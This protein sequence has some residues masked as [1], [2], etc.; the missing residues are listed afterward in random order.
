MNRL[1]ALI[2]VA[3]LLFPSVTFDGLTEAWVARYAG[4][5][6]GRAMT[7]DASDNVYVTGYSC[8]AIDP[9]TGDCSG[10]YLTTLKYG[11]SGVTLWTAHYYPGES[12][13]FF[14]THIATLAL[15]PAGNVYVTGMSA[16]SNDNFNDYVT[17]KYNTADGSQAWAARYGSPRYTNSEPAAIGLDSAGNVYVTGLS[18]DSVS[19]YDFATIKYDPLGTQLWVARFNGPSVDSTDAANALAVDA[20]GNVFVTGSSQNGTGADYTTIKYDTDGNQL[21][22]ARYHGEGSGADYGS[23]IAIDGDGNAYVTGASNGIGTNV[24]YA[25]IKYD[26]DGNQLW[27]ARYDG[28]ASSGDLAVAIV[29]DWAANAYVTG[30]SYVAP[31][32]C[33]YATI[34]YDADG[35]QMWVARYHGQANGRNVA[36]AIAVDSS[37]Y[38]YVTGRSDEIWNYHNYATVA[39]DPDGNEFSVVRYGFGDAIPQ[40]I[41]VDGVGGIYVTGTSSRDYATIKY[42]LQ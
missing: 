20:S 22:V 31:G 33:D 10:N 25:T 21:W 3:V 15:D 32:N 27:V 18:Y 35:N 16:H 42:V 37:G 23:G 30:Y 24:D 8:A 29:V 34:K 13:H 38:T 36:T 5:G 14:S 41:A 39:Y 6:L 1:G 40:A 28:P 17:I 4:P 26:T 19:R 12:F 11:A 9:D 7:V 2:G